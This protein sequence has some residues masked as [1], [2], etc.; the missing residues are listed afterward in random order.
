M[1]HFHKIVYVC[2]SGKTAYSSCTCENFL[3]AYS[4]AKIRK[5]EEF[6]TVMIA[7]VLPPFYESQ[8]TKM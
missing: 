4:S 5:I 7:N 8:C 1:F 2:Y 6:F 3:S